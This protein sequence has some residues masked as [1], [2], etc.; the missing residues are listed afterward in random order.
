MWLAPGNQSPMFTIL[1]VINRLN[2]GQ[3]QCPEGVNPSRWSAAVKFVRN[4]YG[5]EPIEISP[6]IFKD[7]KGFGA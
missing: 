3:T 2:Y 1:F 5:G 7:S 4:Q 6:T